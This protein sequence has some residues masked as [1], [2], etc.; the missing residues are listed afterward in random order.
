MKTI[1]FYGDSNTWGYNSLTDRRYPFEVRF[2][3]IL[4]ER[5]KDQARVIEEGLKG[6]THG[7]GRHSGGGAKR[8][9][10]FADDSM[11]PGSGGYFRNNAGNK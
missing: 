3:G 4:S 1:L 8:L 10:S 6:R 11:Q 9:Q 5:L 7:P 2:T